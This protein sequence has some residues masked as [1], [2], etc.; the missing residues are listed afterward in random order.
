MLCTRMHGWTVGKHSGQLR[1]VEPAL[2]IPSMQ[3]YFNTC[4]CFRCLFC[5][6]GGAPTDGLLVQVWEQ[7]GGTL[8][9]VLVPPYRDIIAVSQSAC[10]SERRSLFGSSFFS[11]K[12]RA[13]TGAYLASRKYQAKDVGFG[14]ARS[15][16]CQFTDTGTTLGSG[17]N[18]QLCLA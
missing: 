10:N 7:V 4:C 9:A 6:S 17:G 3:I 12:P 1:W 11:S 5:H 2:C 13:V 15:L 14:S 8:G 16:C 18:T